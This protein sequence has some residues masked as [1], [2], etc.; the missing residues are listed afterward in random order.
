MHAHILVQLICFVFSRNV[1]LLKEILWDLF[2]S[3]VDELS[4]SKYA[5]PLQG[6][7]EG[8]LSMIPT[9]WLSYSTSKKMS[10][11]YILLLDLSCIRIKTSSSV[12]LYV[13]K[14]LKGWMT[15]CSSLNKTEISNSPVSQSSHICE[16][17]IQNMHY[18]WNNLIWKPSLFWKKKSVTR[19][20]LMKKCCNLKLFW[21]I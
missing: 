14:W 7:E 3:K 20:F 10:Y 18:M 19:D 12:T 2:S 11:T 4:Y 21:W 13:H 9:N 1:G 5:I 6:M 8:V 17:S 16:F 15:T